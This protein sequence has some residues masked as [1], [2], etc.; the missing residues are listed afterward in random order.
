MAKERL[1]KLLVGRGLA[2]SRTKAQA[3]ILAGRVE[4][5]GRRDLKPGTMLPLDLPLSVKGKAHEFVSRGGVKLAG[6]LNELGLVVEGLVCLDVGASTGGFTDCLLRRGALRV[7]AIDV[8]YGQFDWGLR[9][10][11]RVTLIERTNIRYVEPGDFA[12]KFDLAVIDVSFIS[13]QK[14]L[15]PVV[16]LMAEGGLILALVKP[17]FEVGKSLVGKGGVV[18]DEVVR[19]GAVDGVAE[20]ALGMGLE[21]LGRADSP[22][23]GPKGNLET[24]L[25]L[26]CPEV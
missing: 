12:E 2:A 26:G 16:G 19:M 13:L 23:S 9:H 15:G 21:V 18:R 11:G 25:L 1:D 6:A 5:G 20:Y 17:Q 24:F 14:V 7:T 8:G 10:D 3:L 22:I 4:A